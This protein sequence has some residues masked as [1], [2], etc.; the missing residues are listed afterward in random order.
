MDYDAAREILKKYD[1]RLLFNTP[2]GVGSGITRKDGEFALHIFVEERTNAHRWLEKLG[3]MEGLKLEVFETGKIEALTLDRMAKQRPAFGGISV[4]HK[5]IT[6]GTIGSLV[7]DLEKKTKYILSNNHVL[8]N[9]NNAQIGDAVYQPGP[10]DGGTEADTLAYL[11]AFHPII[12]GGVLNYADCAIAEVYDPAQITSEIVELCD[13]V[14]AVYREAGVGENVKKSGRTTGTTTD[15]ILYFSGILAIMY[16]NQQLAYYDDQIVTG[17][18]AAGGDSGSLLLSEDDRPVG[19]LF[20]SS[21]IITIHARIGYVVDYLNILFD[22]D[23]PY[24]Y[25]TGNYDIE[26]YLKTL[27]GKYDILEFEKPLVSIYNLGASPHSIMTLRQLQKISDANYNEVFNLVNDIDAVETA[28]WN[29]DALGVCQGFAPVSR[30]NITF[31]GNGWTIR[32]L[33]IN[34]PTEDGIGL[35]GSLWYSSCDK[36]ILENVNIVGRSYVGGLIGSASSTNLSKCIVRGSVE[37][38]DENIGGMLGYLYIGTVEKSYFEGVVVANGRRY[39][40]G[41]VGLRSNYAIINNC[42]S[43]GVMDVRKLD[44]SQICGFAGSDLRQASQYT[45]CYCVMQFALLEGSAAPVSCSGFAPYL[46]AATACRWDSDICD[47]LPTDTS[48]RSSADMFLADTFPGWNFD[49]IWEI[50]QYK[51]YPRLRLGIYWA[52]LLERFGFMDK[53]NAI[54]LM[55]RLYEMMEIT[56]HYQLINLRDTIPEG[57]GFRDFIHNYLQYLAKTQNNIGFTDYLNVH[58]HSQ[59]FLTPKIGLKDT[60]QFLNWTK[61]LKQNKAFLV[62]RYFC[63]LSKKGGLDP[64]EL[65]MSSFQGRRRK[66]ASTYLSVIIAD[67]S[68][69]QQIIDRSDGILSIY[70]VYELFGEIYLRQMILQV[71]LEDIYYDDGA[72]EQS[73]QLVGHKTYVFSPKTVKIENVSYKRISNGLVTIRCATPDLFLNPGD[74]IITEDENFECGAISYTV[75]TEQSSMEV[76]ESEVS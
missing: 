2:K 40:G 17:V 62:E 19:L 33:Y 16:G 67:G 29:P 20:A 7:W 72:N 50:V 35:F 57:I 28:G 44:P 13:S 41:F 14:G 10:F 37:G 64:I 26:E 51:D 24:K 66:D 23:E 65:P 52:E 59:R 27:G 58:I 1:R 68:Y 71:D 70:M 30:Y 3:N 39:I 46:T 36:I 69:Y 75:S 55:S 11:S 22:G 42:Y 49:S 60:I 61:F 21:Q 5:D 73:I 15:S 63:Y 9:S 34:R 12:F 31:H 56:D 48:A 6:A 45:N 53:I 76:T 74:I 38:R 43:K 4:G 8:A 47:I 54:N 25:L 18:M 32:N